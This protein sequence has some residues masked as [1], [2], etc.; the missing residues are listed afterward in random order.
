[1]SPKLKEAYAPELES[2]MRQTAEGMAHW[3][4]TGPERTTCR[5]CSHW[6]HEGYY[7][8]GKKIGGNALKPGVCSKY[9]ALTRRKG[10]KIPHATPSCKYFEQ[11]DRAPTIQ[12][13]ADA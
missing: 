10:K 9:A 12:K 5:Q 4:A 3:A 11:S 7:S 1:M 6:N 13:P 2:Q 8:A